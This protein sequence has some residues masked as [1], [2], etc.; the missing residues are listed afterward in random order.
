MV[1]STTS[2]W[3]AL[4]AT[5]S[6]EM[7]VKKY[8]DTNQI[9]N[10]LPLEY[11]I[12]EKNGNMVRTLQPVVRNLIFLKSDRSCINELKKKLPIR[13]I[14][15][16]MNG[17]PITVPEI[18]MNN[19]I[20]VA[21]NFDQQIT[22]LSPSEIIAKVGARVRIKEGVFK[23]VE[24]VLTRIKNNNCVVVQIEGL[25]AVATHYIHPSLLENLK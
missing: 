20:A 25:V 3:F 8:C 4:R 21:G 18:Q 24:G 9:L 19:F 11:R 2:V 22:F 23:G 6:R 1:T 12:L 13:Y 17:N 14:M 7:V 10:F 5:Y 15:D 16:R